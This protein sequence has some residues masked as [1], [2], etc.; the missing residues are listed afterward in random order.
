MEPGLHS[1]WIISTLAE[2]L[3][4]HVP[5]G[6]TEVRQFL[7]P[8]LQSS[9]GFLNSLLKFSFDLTKVKNERLFNEGSEEKIQLLIFLAVRVIISYQSSI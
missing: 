9:F 2:C 5:E 7:F 6:E 3:N 8:F 4:K 1:W